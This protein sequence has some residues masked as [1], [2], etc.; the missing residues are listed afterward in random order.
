MQVIKDFTNQH[1]ILA[2]DAEAELD[3]DIQAVKKI[4]RFT[5]AQERYTSRKNYKRSPG[6]YFVPKLKL[7]EGSEWPTMREWM[8][9]DLPDD[10]REEIENPT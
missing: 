2:W 4:D 3:V 6:E 9:K 7:M 1:G 5:A 8:M 10:V